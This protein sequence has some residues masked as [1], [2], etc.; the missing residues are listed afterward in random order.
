M[1]SEHAAPSVS[2]RSAL[3]GLGAGSLGLAAAVTARP[4]AAQEPAA[5]AAHPVVGL[6]QF[7]SMDPG[8]DQSTG[9]EIYHADGTYTSWGG[10]DTGG[11]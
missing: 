9:F 1:T 7:K 10:L 2:R 5:M 8:A 3:A 11:G 6:W 4:A